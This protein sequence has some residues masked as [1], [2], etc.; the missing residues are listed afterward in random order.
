MENVLAKIKE[1]F[2][3]FLENAEDAVIGNKSAGARSRKAS[4]QL[5]KLMKEWRKVSIEEASKK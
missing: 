5:D 3:D 1:G 2:D 4:L